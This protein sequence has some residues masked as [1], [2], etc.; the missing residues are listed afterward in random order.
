[1]APPPP[2]LPGVVVV[3]QQDA[4]AVS[5]LAGGDDGGAAG[6]GATAAGDGDG[7]GAASGKAKK[8]RTIKPCPPSLL[9]L[10]QE[11]LDT[12]A[13]VYKSELN[14]S[15]RATERGP[16]EV[17]HSVKVKEGEVE[18]EYVLDELTIDQLRSFCKTIGVRGYASLSKFLCRL[19]I[20]QFRDHINLYVHSMVN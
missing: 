11:D 9:K 14:P 10:T 1:M 19:A 8:Q 2:P 12:S 15:R 16:F 20:C 17:A 3:G 18:V 4:D 5:Q 13:F 6:L 7:D